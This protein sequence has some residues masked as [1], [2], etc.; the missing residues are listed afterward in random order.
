MPRRSSTPRTSSRSTA[1][2][3]PGRRSRPRRR[4]PPSSSTSATATAGQARTRTTRKYTTKDGFGLNA[5]AGAG[6]YNNK[7][8]GE[9]YIADARARR[10][11]RS[12]C[13]TTSAT[14][15]ATRSRATPPRPSPSPASASTTTRAGFLKGRRRA[16]I[17]D[18]HGGPADTSRPSSRPTRRSSRLWRTAPEC[19]G[20]VKSF[21]ST[22]SPATRRYTDPDTR[23]RATT[24]RSSASRA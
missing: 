7:Y 17:A 8:Y 22:R 3:R 20:H 4:A 24:A 1:R 14:R 23:P 15:R 10:R 2:T 12:S 16:V 5:T 13:C 6:D 18:G 21:A 19:H 11:T 9:P